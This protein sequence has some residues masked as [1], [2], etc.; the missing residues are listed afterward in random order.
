MKNNI[1]VI[2]LGILC[3]LLVFQTGYLIGIGD[4]RSREA[5]GLNLY[6]QPVQRASRSFFVAA[7]TSRETAK[8]TVITINLPGLSKGDIKLQVQ[9]EY[10][11]VRAGRR[12]EMGV[13][14]KYYYSEELSEANFVQSIT[15]PGN[16]SP[17]QIIAEFSNE[18]L[19]I[20]I[21]K[22]KRARRPSRK[23]ITIPV[24]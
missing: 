7:M 5:K 3:G 9:G 8:A 12:R 11:I 10:L 19:T 17:E 15:L 21:P 22:D 23:T 16:V 18:N 20:I 14:N 13:A 1:L 4:E 6:R 2:S 24:R